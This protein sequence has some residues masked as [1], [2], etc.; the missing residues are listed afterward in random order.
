LTTKPG[1]ATE[2]TIDHATDL[3]YVLLSEEHCGLLV[4][5]RGWAPDAWQSWCISVV[6]SVLFPQR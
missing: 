4:V 3:L 1:F 5:E 2:L 6:E